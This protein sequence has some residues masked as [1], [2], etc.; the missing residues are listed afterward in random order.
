MEMMTTTTT[1]MMMMMTTTTTMMMMM[2]MM[3]LLLLLP[4]SRG[5]FFPTAHSPH[6]LAPGN[7]TL[8][9]PASR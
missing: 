7:S 9:L 8:A 1:T 3:L 6:A 2:M 5:C 4:A